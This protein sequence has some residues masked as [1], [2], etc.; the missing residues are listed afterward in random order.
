M[1]TFHKIVQA[2]RARMVTDPNTTDGKWIL[3]SLVNITLG[4]RISGNT[5]MYNHAMS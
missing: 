4:Y 2:R 5:L 1:K 3:Q